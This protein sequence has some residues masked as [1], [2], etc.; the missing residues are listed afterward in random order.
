M[1]VR[2]KSELIQKKKEMK[3]EKETKNNNN[4]ARKKIVRLINKNVFFFEEHKIT[5]INTFAKYQKLF[6]LVFKANFSTTILTYFK[7]MFEK[8][9]ICLNISSANSM[10]CYI[11]D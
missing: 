8:S 1:R 4:R 11:A 3:T 9:N 10:R 5:T 2:H 7:Y 6:I